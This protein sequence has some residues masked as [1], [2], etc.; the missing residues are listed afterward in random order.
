MRLILAVTT[1][2]AAFGCTSA[3]P[4]SDVS[5]ASVRRPMSDLVQEDAEAILSGMNRARN[6]MRAGL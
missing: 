5:D 2:L 1:L 6:G 4:S 3:V